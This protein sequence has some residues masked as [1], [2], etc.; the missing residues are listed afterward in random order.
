MPRFPEFE[1]V[2]DNTPQL[3][4]ILDSN[5]KQIRCSK[6]ADVA[7]A[8]ALQL[9]TDG[10][11][12]DITGV[13]A[14]TSINTLGVGTMVTLHFDGILTL[15]HHTTDLI[16]PSGANIITAVGDEVTLIEYAAGDWRCVVYT[17]SSG[18]AVVGGGVVSGS[19]SYTGNNT[20]NRAIP[21][22][23]GVVPFLIVIIDNN[24]AGAFIGLVFDDLIVSVGGVPVIATSYAVTA[25]DATNFYV[26]NAA[27]YWGS[28]NSSQPRYYEWRILA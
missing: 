4:G 2:K 11:H 9:G 23:L 6:G 18:E 28:L 19:G 25:A 27:E 26:G 8:T 22:G 15:T 20:V 14:I 3:G 21:H 12:F 17:K 24:N 16:L 1:L 13:T 10:N 7:S 5:S